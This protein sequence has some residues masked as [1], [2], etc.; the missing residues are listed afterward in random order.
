MGLSSIF[1][2]SLKR[3]REG[4]KALRS[5]SLWGDAGR[6]QAPPPPP[7]LPSPA[8]PLLLG[9]LLCL[10][11][12]AGLPGGETQNQALLVGAEVGVVVTKRTPEKEDDLH[13]SSLLFLPP[14]MHT[15]GAAG[16]FKGSPHPPVGRA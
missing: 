11:G 3:P 8:A 4:Q 14:L 6:G 9:F 10:L 15:M 1:I 5:H 13:C 7:Y 2:P 12:E 16:L